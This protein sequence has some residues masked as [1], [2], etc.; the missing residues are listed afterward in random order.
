VKKVTHQKRP[1]SVTR[2]KGGLTYAMR[3]PDR[4]IGRWGH[5]V[6]AETVLGRFQFGAR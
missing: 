5:Y 1:K 2:T 3:I 4:R 6:R